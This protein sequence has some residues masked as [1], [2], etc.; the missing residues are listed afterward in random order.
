MQIEENLRG[1]FATLPDGGSCA[2]KAEW[3]YKFSFLGQA[4]ADSGTPN[5][6]SRL[7]VMGG[8]T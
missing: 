8:L 7:W 2:C 5:L 1:T 4:D 6:I 3:S